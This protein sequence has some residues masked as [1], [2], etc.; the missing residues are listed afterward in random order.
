MIWKK[1]N[2][3][4][5]KSAEVSISIYFYSLKKKKMATRYSIDHVHHKVNS[6]QGASWKVENMGKIQV[7]IKVDIEAPAQT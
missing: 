3:S 6:S 5:N 7:T 4:H 1:G 2:T